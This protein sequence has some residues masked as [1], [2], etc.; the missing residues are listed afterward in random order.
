[1]K[2]INYKTETYKI[3]LTEE[4]K[5]FIDSIKEATNL[6]LPKTKKQ[7]QYK[8]SFVY[9]SL[10]SFCKVH[11]QFISNKLSIIQTGA[12]NQMITNS[13]LKKTILIRIKKNM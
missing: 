7:K 5:S 12:R 4:S 13:T 11:S 6:Y 8:S 3:T 9:F 1:M 10:F 2:P